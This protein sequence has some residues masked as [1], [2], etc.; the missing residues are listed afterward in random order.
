[1][2]RLMIVDDH[3]YLIEGLRKF[4]NWNELNLEVLD[5]AANGEE[6]LSKIRR[7]RPDIVLTDISM[8]IMDGLVMI[9]TLST[10]G[11]G[12]KFIILTGHGEFEYAREA[13]K[14]GVM[15]FILKPVMPREIT[16]VLRRAVA[17]CESERWQREQEQRMKQQLLE[18]LPV[19]TQRFMEELFEGAIQTQAEFD[20]RAKLLNLDLGSE[21]GRVLSVEIDD[22]GRFLAEHDEGE[23]RFLKFSLETALCEALGVQRSFLGFRERRATL[24][25]CQ[26][27]PQEE[28]LA[29][30]LEA[31]VRKLQDAHGIGLTVGL[32][33]AVPTA[34]QIH[35][36]YLQSLEG[37]RAQG[38]GGVPPQPQ[39][40]ADTASIGWPKAQ[41]QE[42]LLARSPEKLSACLNLFLSDLR[43]APRLDMAQARAA[44]ADMLAEM[45]RMLAQT[46]P[47]LAELPEAPAPELQSAQTLPE[48]E[49]HLRN[50]FLRAQAALSGHGDPR[51]A[52]IIEQVLEAI[53]RDYDKD[54]TLQDLARR[55]YLTP[56]YL[57][58][59]FYKHMGRSFL[60]Y[61]AQYR[62]QKAADLLESGKYLIYEVSEMVGYRDHDYFRRVFKDYMGVTPSQFRK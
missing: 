23:R 26:P 57:G 39:P 35:T 20:S 41:L 32:G 9:R 25:L 52:R 18:S 38:A 60:D 24:L 7:M 44:A 6:G 21:G 2:Y 16:E 29:A 17:A 15:D 28:V 33:S 48:L 5:V 12:C 43:A 19:L 40:Q 62:M 14:Y 59:I 22:Y 46:A 4:I 56:N 36:S 31:L 47:Y 8:P 34:L 11:L 27:L 42:A 10:E 50:T 54:L 49:T 53:R 51:T 61:L 3:E 55:V 58:T 30:R 13:I 1:M 37:L 45:A